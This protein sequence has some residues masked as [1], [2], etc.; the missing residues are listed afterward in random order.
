MEEQI[1]RGCEDRS[2]HLNAGTSTEA[3]GGSGVFDRCPLA[4]SGAD[5]VG[6][7]LAQLVQSR[8]PFDVGDHFLELAAIHP[9]AAATT[10]S[11]EHDV[12]VVAVVEGPHGGLA[13]WAGPLLVPPNDLWLLVDNVEIQVRNILLPREVRR[14]RAHLAIVEPESTAGITA[15]QLDAEDVLGRH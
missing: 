12:R 2:H 5:L 4:V 11:V 15:V 9:H 10:A 1:H 7:R 13:P 6:D 8:V 14:Q 3:H